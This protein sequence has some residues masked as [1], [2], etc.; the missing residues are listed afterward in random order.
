MASRS[1]EQEQAY[2]VANALGDALRAALDGEM[3]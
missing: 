2:S 3:A 1:V